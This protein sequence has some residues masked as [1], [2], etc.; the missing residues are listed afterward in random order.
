MYDLLHR[1]IYTFL[2][3]RVSASLP[4]KTG[5]ASRRN[6]C[7]TCLCSGMIRKGN[8]TDEPVILED[9]AYT[10][11]CAPHC[12]TLHDH[13]Q[14]LYK[15]CLWTE[16]RSETCH[17]CH[18]GVVTPR[19]VRFDSS[20]S[21]DRITS[22]HHARPSPPSHQCFHPRSDIHAPQAG[23]PAT[24][25]QPKTTKIMRSISPSF[26]R[27]TLAHCSSIFVGSTVQI[28]S[29]VT[30]GYSNTTVVSTSSQRIIKKHVVQIGSERSWLHSANFAV[31]TTNVSRSR[32]YRFSPAT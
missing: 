6:V 32:A 22:N 12:T 10:Y 28:T 27:A 26:A 15:T 13:K 29:T 3:E 9:K 24:T 5:I 16:F 4:R 19:N 8:V 17:L 23:P 31:V 21:C 2:A 7:P 25:T 14:L 30:S 1:T 20:K 18:P 11:V